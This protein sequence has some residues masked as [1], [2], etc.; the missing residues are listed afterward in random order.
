MNVIF[1]LAKLEENVFY[2]NILLYQICVLFSATYMCE[3]IA[4]AIMVIVWT[5]ESDFMINPK[6]S[7]C[8]H[9]FHIRTLKNCTNST[10]TPHKAH[11]DGTAGVI[12]LA[13]ID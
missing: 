1:E 2:V 5:M 10:H 6:V 11:N 3:S 4:N 13:I 8:Y 12:L 9:R 7:R